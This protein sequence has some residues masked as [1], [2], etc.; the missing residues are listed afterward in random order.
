M[1]AQDFAGTAGAG[2]GEEDVIT[3]C[4]LLPELDFVAGVAMLSTSSSDAFDSPPT[5]I[6]PCAVGTV[7]AAIVAATTS[8][9]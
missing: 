8:A 4:V 7:A 6:A 2:A 1:P 9:I 5:L 3:A